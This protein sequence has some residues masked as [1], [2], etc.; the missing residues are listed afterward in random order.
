MIFSDSYPSTCYKTD[1]GD[2]HKPLTQGN[3]KDGYWL[4]ASDSNILECVGRQCGGEEVMIEGECQD[5]FDESLCGG[6]GEAIFLNAKGEPSCE[7]KEGWG[8]KERKEEENMIVWGGKKNIMKIATVKSGGRCYQE[9]MLG[10]CSRNMI[11]KQFEANLFGCII[12]PCGDTNQ[13]F[14]H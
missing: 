10:F 5:I 7:C 8:R 3:C 12:N 6:L 13:Q 9:Y 11:V 1:N 4:V 2:C 14:P